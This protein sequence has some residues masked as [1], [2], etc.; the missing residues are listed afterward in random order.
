MNSLLIIECSD[1]LLLLLTFIAHSYYLFSLPANGT[2]TEPINPYPTVQGQ[3]VLT[4][5]QQTTIEEFEKKL[6]E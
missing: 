1:L 3:T 2:G 6:E 5:T 4:A